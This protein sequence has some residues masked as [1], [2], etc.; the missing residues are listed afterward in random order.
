MKVFFGLPSV[1]YNNIINLTILLL[2][3]FSIENFNVIDSSKG[4]LILKKK[5]TLR[6]IEHFFTNI[7]FN[8]EEELSKKKK[9]YKTS[10]L[11]GKLSVK[12]SKKR[13]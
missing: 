10:T 1:M 6:N 3:I 11:S 12:G 4:N 2:T 8:F 9:R 7:L 5:R 13:I